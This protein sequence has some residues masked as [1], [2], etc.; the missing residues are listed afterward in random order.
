MIITT[1]TALLVLATQS[2]DSSINKDEIVRKE[3]ETKKI[4]V[5]N[6][7]VIASKKHQTIENLSKAVSVVTRE[8]IADKDITLLP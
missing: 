2:N 5:E 6:V 7:T 4:N 1:F 8:E 3:T